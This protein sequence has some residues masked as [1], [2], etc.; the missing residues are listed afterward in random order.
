[1]LLSNRLMKGKGKKRELGNCYP[2]PPN[3]DPFGAGVTLDK[4]LGAGFRMAG[5]SFSAD[6][7]RMIMTPYSSVTSTEYLLSVPWEIDSAVHNRSLPKAPTTYPYQLQYARNGSSLYTVAFGVNH[8]ALFQNVFPNEPFADD[9]VFGSS[10]VSFVPA[11]SESTDSWSS[12]FVS[13]DERY[14]FV[15]TRGDEIIQYEMSNPGDITSCIFIRKASFPGNAWNACW[16]SCDGINLFWTNRND[17]Y[18]FVLSTP[19]D[20]STAVEQRMTTV[21][22]DALCG[23]WCN[24]EMTIMYTS[25]Y[26]A[27]RVEQFSI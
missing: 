10:W 4:T 13:D 22:H 6:G 20:I 1:M 26:M 5:V 15:A 23:L 14:V 18:H 7:T 2:S 12:L 19:F 27:S 24:P 25:R 9:D 16:L 8:T 3:E 11:A 17:V 21:P